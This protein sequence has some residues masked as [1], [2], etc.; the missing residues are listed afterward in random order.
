MSEITRTPGDRRELAGRLDLEL[1]RRLLAL[2]P[3]LGDHASEAAVGGG[4]LEDALR[5]RERPVDVVDLRGEELGLVDGRVGRRLD[6]PE[7]DALVFLRR[8]LPL[9]EHVEGDD[10][11]GDDRPQGED[12]R[13]IV[14]SARQQAGV[15]LPDDLE[16]PVD[17]PGEAAVGAAGAQEP[18]AHHRGERERHDSGDD[19]G[20]GEGERELAE[21][22]A[23]QASLDA[24]RRVHRRQRDR[25]GDDRAGELPRRLDRGVERLFSQVEMPLHVLDDDDRVVHDETDGQ[26]DAEKRQKVDREPGHQHQE[27]GADERNGDRD[28]RDE[29]RPE[30]AEE[31][32]DDEDDD[33]ERD[34]QG[35]QDLADRVLDVGGRVVRDPDLHADGQLRPDVGDRVA[36][37]LDHGEGVGGRQHPDPHERGG[38]PV[39]PDIGLVV[40]GAEHHVGDL[41]QPHDDALV[42]LDHELAELL[43]GLEVGVGDEV[44]RHHGPVRLAQGGER[45]VVRQRAAHLRRRDLEGG[46]PVGLQPDPHRERP[47]AQDVGALHAGD[48]RE[49]GLD[50]ARQVIGDLVLVEVLGGEPDVDRRELRV[51]GLQVDDRRLGLR[52][53][54]VTD[55]RDFRLDLRQGGVGVVVQFQVHGDR[56]HPLRARGFHVVDAVRAGDDPFQ[57]RGDEAS[58][59]VGVGADVRRRHLHDRDVRP[60]ELPHRQGPDRLQPGDQDH[61]A[62]DDGEDRTPDEEVG[63]FHVRGP[64]SCLRVSGPG[65]FRVGSCC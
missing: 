58:D 60:R 4:D 9:R 41:A 26:H 55:L 2:A 65:C 29:H 54:V 25:H 19:H 14:E 61:Q 7:H 18:G 42:F 50:D 39:E 13:A 44:D 23:G 32:E 21:E 45:V 53:E 3:G 36:H 37:V 31:E 34:R 35:L 56:A 27:D 52:R 17:H 20:A 11:Q 15:R 22:R 12:D 30:G 6:E 43:G 57:R 28:D 59:E 8:E 49:L 62:D 38:L 16:V 40:L 64:L 48:R 46:H 51:R 24:D 10:Q 33:Q 5:F 47:A 63:E 1:F